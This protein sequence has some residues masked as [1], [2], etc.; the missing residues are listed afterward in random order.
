[1]YVC[2]FM[3]QSHS[4]VTCLTQVLDIHHSTSKASPE[5]IP[6][7]VEFVLGKHKN[8]LCVCFLSSNEPHIH[9]YTP[10]SLYMQSHA[11]G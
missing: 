3:G 11:R 2:M 4:F 1:M 7:D 9:T 10:T 6:D 8:N 5:L